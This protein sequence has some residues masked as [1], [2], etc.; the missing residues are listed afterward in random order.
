MHWKG[1]SKH[2]VPELHVKKEDE[3]Y[4]ARTDSDKAEVFTKEN[5]NYSTFLD[6][7]PYDEELSNDEISPQ[8][9]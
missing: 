7:I 6:D 8:E 2:G 9:N 4:I 1:N 3:T 5:D